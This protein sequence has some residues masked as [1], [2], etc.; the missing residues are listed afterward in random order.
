MRL[1]LLGLSA[2][3]LCA[4]QN[5]GLHVTSLPVSDDDEATPCEEQE[6]VYDFDSDGFGGNANPVLTCD[7]MSMQGY[8]LQGGDCNDANLYVNP[9]A[10]EV[11]DALDND[12]DGQINENENVDWWVD[13]DADGFGD[14]DLLLVG[15]CDG[16]SF[17]VGNSDDCNDD[18]P[19]VNPNATEVCDQIDNDCDG[20]MDDEDE[21][22]DLDTATSWNVDVDGDGFG[23]NEVDLACV[24]PA[25]HVENNSEDC[26]DANPVINP[27]AIEFCDL[28]DNDCDGNSDEG[29]ELPFWMD[30]D[31]DGYG[32]LASLGSACQTPD[33]YV[34]NAL[35]CDDSEAV[36]NPGVTEVCDSADTDEDCDTMA[37]DADA[38][39]DP[40]SM[41]TFYRDADVDS[42]GNV[43]VTASACSQPT[44]YVVDATDCDDASASNYPGA[45]EVCDALDND[46]DGVADNGVESTFYQDGDS[47]SFGNVGVTANACVAPSGYV[48][49][50]TDCDDADATVY[51]GAPE[52]CDNVDDDCD[53]TV[54]ESADDR[55]TWFRDFDSD[56][57][58]NLAISVLSCD[59]PT[60]FVDSA[61]DCNDFDASVNPA[62]TEVFNSMDDDC[63]GQVDEGLTCAVEILIFDGGGEAVSITG[64]VSDD[65]ALS[66]GWYPPPGVSGVSVTP[67]SLGGDDWE[68]DIAFDQCLSS[69]GTI[70]VDG[71]FTDGSSVCDDPTSTIYG[72][73]D[74][75]GLD[76]VVV[77]NADTTCAIE[78][79]L[80]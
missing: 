10:T 43:S 25:G 1:F 74:E 22:L 16:K 36:V 80:P 44:G 29:V 66:G 41:F 5:Y 23:T 75:T 61:G 37:D 59:A 45:P 13:G 71:E 53:G 48:A 4:C 27:D 11:C 39:T 31:E 19:T 63:D 33:G 57:Y 9:D 64:D 30:S 42:F 73:M 17:A 28:Q 2:A 7:D 78:L 35:D 34:S 6:W 49:N 50:S 46:C 24:M 12:C 20:A 32:D 8:S 62:A 79:S 3:F 69:S 56:S 70:V 51:P 21:S 68:Y 76:S 40:A 47:D 58:G 38:S 67:V 54:D 52:F 14:P 26:D 55:T 15:G 60:G 72:W 18:D 77:V 65:A